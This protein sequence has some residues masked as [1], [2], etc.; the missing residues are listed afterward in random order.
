MKT[1]KVDILNLGAFILNYFFKNELPINPLKLQKLLYYI[2]AWHLVYF[3]NENIFEDIPEAWVNGPVYPKVYDKL[4]HIQLYNF[5]G[6]KDKSK[7]K[8]DTYFAKSKESLD[9]TG[10]QWEFLESILKHYGMMT[11]EKLVFL[12]HSEKPWLEAREGVGPFE[13]SNNNISLRTMYE[14]YTS[15][16]KK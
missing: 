2:Q 5:I 16:L 15:Q 3:D 7:E 11:H 9:I 4:K 10:E 13:Y 1:R 8:L 6:L 14:Y 12:T